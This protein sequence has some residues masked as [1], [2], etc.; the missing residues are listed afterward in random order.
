M[1]LDAY[2]L[3]LPQDYDREGYN[4]LNAKFGDY[5]KE[6]GALTYVEAVADDVSRGER[7]DFY[8]AVNADEAETVAVA[9]I[10]WPDKAMRDAAWGAMETD[11]R[12]AD[13]KPEDMP[14]DGK[15]MF[16]GGFTPVYEMA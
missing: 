4:A 13:M 9:F 11:P 2:V 16:W 5:M 6:A 15:R 7:T 10:T 3:P 8:R 1:Y 12:F 14:F